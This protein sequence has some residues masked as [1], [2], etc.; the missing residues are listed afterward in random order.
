MKKQLVIVIDGP[1]GAGKSTVSQRLAKKLGYLYLDTG[2][3][4]RCVALSALQRD[5]PPRNSRKLLQLAKQCKISFKKSGS[6]QHV[7][8]N[9]VDVTRKIRTHTLSMLASRYSCLPVVRQALLS[10]QR[11][12]GKKGGMVAE[13]RDLGTIVFPNADLKFFMIATLKERAKRRYVEVSKK[14]K[15]VSLKAV[16]RDIQIRDR[17]DAKRSLAP[18]KKSADAIE[19]DTTSLTLDQVVQEIYRICREKVDE[20]SY[21]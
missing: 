10:Q 1:S 3:L 12:F 2:A 9:G 8:L 5:I 15:N 19:I 6:R 17:V 13:G 4:Y 14:P 21:Q 16:E 18:L 7:F 11:Y 20:D